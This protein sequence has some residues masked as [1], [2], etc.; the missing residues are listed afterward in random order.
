M[1]FEP[2]RPHPLYIQVA[3]QMREAIYAGKLAPGTTV[4]TERELADEFEVSRSSVR[5]ALRV[6]EAQGLIRAGGSTGRVV[7]SITEGT[8]IYSNLMQALR[9]QQA[10]LKALIELRSILESGAMVLAAKSAPEPFLDEAEALI[11]EMEAAGVS[12]EEYDA[13]NSKFHLTLV[14]ACGN[15]AIISVLRLSREV[16][17][18]HLPADLAE[19]PDPDNTLAR[20]NQ[21]H[22]EIVDALRKGDGQKAADLVVLHVQSAY[23]HGE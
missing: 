20:M 10:S 4:P 7:T 22:R 3:E 23:R 18:G 9:L 19:D 6:V 12:P 17:K 15:D 1:P 16:L 5:E 14:S 13:I 11:E 8:P 21:E 2:A